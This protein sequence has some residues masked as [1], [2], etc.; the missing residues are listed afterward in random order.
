MSVHLLM[1]YLKFDFCVDFSLSNQNIDEN[2]SCEQCSS[3]RVKQ[4]DLQF[5]QWEWQ[6]IVG[7]GREQ[8]W[9]AETKLWICPTIFLHSSYS[10][11]NLRAGDE[12]APSYWT[13]PALERRRFAVVDAWSRSFRG[14]IRIWERTGLLARQE[15]LGHLIPQA[16][17]SV[18]VWLVFVQRILFV[19]C[20]W[21]CS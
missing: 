12:W 19:L 16:S 9:M 5:L 15:L 20:S 10:R 17:A 18:T 1:M 21:H 13:W 11:W 8:R 4:K 7:R 6:Q 14:R 3:V 2:Q